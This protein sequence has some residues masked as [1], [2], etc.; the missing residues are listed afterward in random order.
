[1]GKAALVIVFGTVLYVSVSQMSSKD[2]QDGVS[3]VK[4]EFQENTL[5]SEIARSAFGM[6][7]RRA[8]AV[9][10]SA[11]SVLTV[12]NGSTGSTTGDYQGGTYEYSG[13]KRSD[14]LIAISAKGFFGGESHEIKRTMRINH[15]PSTSWEYSCNATGAN[16]V[17]MAGIGMGSKGS[18]TNNGSWI[19]LTDTTTIRYMKAQV[20]GRVSDLKDVSFLTSTGQSVSLTKPDTTGE[21]DM[22]YFQADV[23]PASGVQVDV[24]NHSSRNNGA[25]GFVVYAHRELPIPMY[26]NGRYLDVRMYHYGHTETF[27]IPTSTVPRDV[28]VDFVMYDKDDRRDVTLTIEAVGL[29]ESRTVVAPNK[30][31]E[32]AIETLTLEGVP[33]DV[34]TILVTIYSNDSL[35]WKMAHVYTDGC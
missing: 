6:A 19:T 33:G 27:Q 22:G 1:M 35:Y 12:L 25:R 32:L 2:T 15:I 14:N 9:N 8:R 11:D 31:K 3:E 34:T 18:L 23:E 16:F 24:N 21:R 5:A 13:S 17:E 10:G 28:S 4:V 7:E 20:G 26:S 30:E 29:S